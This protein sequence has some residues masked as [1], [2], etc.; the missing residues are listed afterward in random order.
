MPFTKSFKIK[1]E[2]GVLLLSKIV[3]L[4]RK[5]SDMSKSNRLTLH[6]YP[7][8]VSAPFSGS[9]KFIALVTN[10]ISLSS[11]CV[12]LKT[13]AASDEDLKINIQK[14]GID[15]MTT[16]YTLDNT[17]AVGSIIRIPLP[18]NKFRKGDLLELKM[19]HTPGAGSTMTDLFGSLDFRLVN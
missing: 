13:G 14:N 15:V 2:E 19:T 3:A 16:D 4:N 10:S 6:S 8:S 1:S 9:P 7:L 12:R 17:S 11:L 18:D 5:S